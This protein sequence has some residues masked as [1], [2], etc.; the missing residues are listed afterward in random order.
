MTS[1]KKGVERVKPKKI[2]EE[3]QPEII[4]VKQPLSSGNQ[5]ANSNKNTQVVQ[6]VFPEDTEIRKVKKKKKG[7][8][9]AQKKK[10]EQREELL[11]QLKQR[12]EEYDRLQEEAQKLKIKIPESLGIK[13]ISKADLKTNEDIQNYI[14]DVI[15]KI[16]KLQELVKKPQST[17]M[18]LPMRL[19]SGINILPTLPPQFT[20]QQPPIIPPQRPPIIPPQ[21]PP[22]E[23]DKTK[24]R[25]DKIARDVEKKFVE[26]G[27]DLPAGSPFTPEKPDQP[28]GK[29]IPIEEG[30]LVLS[31]GIKYGDKRIDVEAPKGWE[32]I[33]NEYRIFL[34]SVEFITAKNEILDG[35]YHIPL[36]KENELF[37]TKDQIRKDYLIWFNSLDRNLISYIYNNQL[38]N[39]IDKDI[40]ETTQ[41]TPQKI[42]EKLFTEQGVSFKEITG[43][44]EKS[45]I[46]E[47]IGETKNPFKKDSD[48]RAYTSYETT[49]YTITNKLIEVKKE[50]TR[51]ESSSASASPRTIKELEDRL[52][53]LDKT[54]DK[55]YNS[56]NEYV[57]KGVM[58]RN[59]ELHKRINDT[60]QQLSNID[61]PSPTDPSTP[62]PSVLP[63]ESQD[64]AINNLKNFTNSKKSPNYT[65]KI[66]ASV[67]QI[68]GEEIYTQLEKLKPADRRKVIIERFIK[69]MANEDPNWKPDNIA[70]RGPEPIQPPNRTDAIMDDEGVMRLRGLPTGFVG[71]PT[72]I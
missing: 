27:G 31:K 15:N 42:A 29:D 46:E 37:T 3:P 67:L 1:K 30:D 68:F 24:E 33:Y 71:G 21:E 9:Q 14:N 50:I 4:Q 39:Q 45:S 25:L 61:N 69:F 28:A 60:R 58:S 72:T 18:G 26:G 13:V 10:E 51:L 36:E 2:K 43:G 49:Y 19:G 7:K 40:R 53:N 12:L 22:Q 48:N 70:D 23:P 62:D 41:L 16:A 63:I 59:D 11:N 66:R 34:E 5:N 35:V 6:I 17:S 20:P 54:L 8:S 55:A 52:N 38:L 44:N 47:L 56:L 65:P 32:K 57:V 64:E